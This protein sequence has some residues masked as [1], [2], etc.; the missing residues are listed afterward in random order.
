[1]QLQYCTLG[2]TFIPSYKM[3]L[4]DYLLHKQHL[5]IRYSEVICYLSFAKS[6]LSNKKPPFAII[7]WLGSKRRR[8]C[9]NYGRWVANTFRVNG[10]ECVRS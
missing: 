4:I 2:G 9:V 10:V 1:M 3:N 6:L 5:N 8:L 7:L